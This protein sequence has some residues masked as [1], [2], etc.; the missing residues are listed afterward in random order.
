VQHQIRR[1]VKVLPRQCRVTSPVICNEDLDI[2]I[3]TD[4][5]NRTLKR[6]H[7]LSTF[8]RGI[9]SMRDEVFAWKINI[10]GEFV[11]SMPNKLKHALIV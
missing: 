5:V 2:L 10:F 6:W 3:R 1:L 8:F 9:V 4:N 11:K 7:N